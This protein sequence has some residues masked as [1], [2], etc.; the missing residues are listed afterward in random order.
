MLRDSLCCAT[1][2]TSTLNKKGE[3]E[4][5]EEKKKKNKSRKR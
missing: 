1:R 5:K 2:Y 3:I 4:E